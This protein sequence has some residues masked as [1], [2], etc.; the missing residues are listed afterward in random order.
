VVKLLISYVST[1]EEK[2]EKSAYCIKVQIQPDK[3]F[4]AIILSSNYTNLNLQE[5]GKSF[6]LELCKNNSV[7]SECMT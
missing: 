7:D 3:D 4:F 5:I 2:E 1:G 6:I